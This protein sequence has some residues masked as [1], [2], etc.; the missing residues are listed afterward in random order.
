[1]AFSDCQ[2]G[3]HPAIRKHGEFDIWFGSRKRT[4]RLKTA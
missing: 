3:M 2:M 4:N 1:M